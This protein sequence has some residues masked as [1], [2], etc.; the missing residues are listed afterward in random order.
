MWDSLNKIIMA[1][2]DK[3]QEAVYEAVGIIFG[4]SGRMMGG[5]WWFFG[6]EGAA[7]FLLKSVI[8][9]CLAEVRWLLLVRDCLNQRL[10]LSTCCA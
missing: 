6:R 8:D 5:L 3:M 10:P 2:V 1:I 7:G 4:R 9:V